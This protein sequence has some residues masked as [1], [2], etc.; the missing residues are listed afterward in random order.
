MSFFIVRLRVEPTYI[1]DGRGPTQHRHRPD[2]PRTRFFYRSLGSMSIGRDASS[3][4]ESAFH[5]GADRTLAAL[6]ERIEDSLGDE[7]DV[8]LQGG[9]LTIELAS[10]GQYVINKH[11][12][13]RQIWL[14][15][16]TSGASHFGHEPGRGWIS[17][18]GGAALHELLAQ[19]LSTATGMAIELDPES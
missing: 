4:D 6:L 19:E 17:T 3:D 12:P 9:I 7:L 10:G 11:A 8:D 15:S 13:N 18:R 1:S 2:R 5:A 14:S 16:P